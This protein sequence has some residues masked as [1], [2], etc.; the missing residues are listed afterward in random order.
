MLA[1]A[2]RARI[3]S[4]RRPR[5][6]DRTSRDYQRRIVSRLFDLNQHPTRSRM[7]VLENI[8]SGVDGADRHIAADGASDFAR[9]VRFR[10]F[11]QNAAHEL[12][13]SNAPIDVARALVGRELGPA[14]RIAQNL[15]VILTGRCDCDGAIAL[16]KNIEWTK[17]WSAIPGRL[18]DDAG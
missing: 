18:T 3:N 7:R 16:R 11:A 17:H 6:L 12:G 4:R 9:G 5:Q 2:R 14:D 15:P 8:F 10:P 1:Q 13:V